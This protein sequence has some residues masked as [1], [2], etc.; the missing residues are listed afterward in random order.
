MSEA[1]SWGPTPP[2]GLMQTGN[3]RDLVWRRPLCLGLGLKG[4]W[5]SLWPR[6]GVRGA[7]GW[8]EAAWHRGGQ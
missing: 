1:L 6:A 4:E 8:P 2:S 7:F 3:W 5:V